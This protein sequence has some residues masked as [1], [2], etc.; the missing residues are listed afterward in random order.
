MS[1]VSFAAQNRLWDTASV[2]ES[3]SRIKAYTDPRPGYGSLGLTLHRD[4][5]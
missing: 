2:S 1:E 5:L 4:E 3:N